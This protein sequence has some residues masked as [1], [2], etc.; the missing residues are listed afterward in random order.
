MTYVMLIVLALGPQI[1][2]H[3]SFNWALRYLSPTLV[4]VSILGEPIGSSILAYLI[5]QEVP[6]ALKVVG[7][8]VILLGIYICSRAESPGGLE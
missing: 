2:G 5:L 1:L 7:G 3:S 4:T 8:V 6:S